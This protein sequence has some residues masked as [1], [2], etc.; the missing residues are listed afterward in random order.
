MH[1]FTKALLA[2]GLVFVGSQAAQAQQLLDNFENTRLVN[3]PTPQGTFTVVAN[4]GSSTANSSASC[5]SYVRDGGQPYATLNAVLNS[6]YKF[7]SVADYV[8]GTKRITMKFRSMAPVGTSI[9]LVLQNRAK[10][11]VTPYVYPQGNFSGVFNATTTATNAWETLTFTY[12]AATSDPTVTATDID[13]I[14]M[15]IAPN[16]SSALTYYI[17]DLMGPERAAAPP[18]ATDQLLDNHDGTRAIKYKRNR[19]GGSFRVDT[20]NPYKVTG[21]MSNNVFRYSRSTQ[22]YD[23]LYMGPV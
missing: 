17:D 5:G 12:A 21:N 11:I 14:A 4:P 18:V 2:A 19:T 20:L 10:A 22:Q 8:A 13:Q 23:G 3:Y 6:N 16:S 9:Q 7:A 1:N 15:L